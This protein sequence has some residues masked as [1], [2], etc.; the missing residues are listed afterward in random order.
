L[1]TLGLSG[2]QD[3][4]PGSFGHYE[5]R[6]QIGR[7]SMGVVYEA[8]HVNL[9]RPVALKMISDAQLASPLAR[10][11]FAIEAEAAAK[12]DH[13]NIVRIFEFGEWDGQPFLT[14]TL[15]QGESLREKIARGEIRALSNDG[16]TTNTGRFRAI[17]KMMALVARAVHHAHEHGVLHRDLKPANILIDTRGQPHLTDFGLAK[18]LDAPVPGPAPS[19][20]GAVLGT[21]CYMSPE[22]ATGQRLS[23][24]TDVYGL[25]AVLYELLTGRPPFKAPTALETMR[26]LTEQAPQRPRNLQ[27]QIPKD[28][29]TVCLKCLERHPDSRYHSAEALAEDLERWLEQRPILARPAKPLVRAARW[30]RRNPLGAALIVSL[31]GCLAGTLAWLH[32]TQKER[33]RS[34]TVRSALT[35]Q[36]TEQIEALWDDPKQ[37]FVRITALDLASLCNY[38]APVLGRMNTIRLT[39]DLDNEEDPIGQA[40]AHAPVLRLLE[41]KMGR[42]LHRPVVFDIR[43]HKPGRDPV[44]AAALGLADVQR[45]GPLYYVRA[46]VT[47]PGLE[48]I[49]SERVSKEAVIFARE[50]LGL[51]N[52]AQAKGLRIAFAHTNACISFWAMVHFVRAGITAANIARYSNLDSSFTLQAEKTFQDAENSSHKIVIER[53]L[54]GEF[55]L[56]ESRR[57]QF[58]RHRHRGLV[59]LYRFS[60]TPDLY[61]ARPGLD[62]KVVEALREALV[63]F[64]TPGEKGLLRKLHESM[65]DGFE[66]ASDADFD[67][68]RTALTTE[69]ARFEAP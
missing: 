10:R 59:E 26:L 63:S 8:M 2:E 34:E 36:L 24:A 60:A 68:I 45:M 32:L 57:N 29:E 52:L 50:E 18:I 4:F 6:R 55:D 69:V 31:C 15:V 11:R 58:E 42:T 43:V 3:L 37:S 21:P 56:G 48:P 67:E 64:S 40:M 47:A 62:P 41:Q 35:W 54:A 23:A 25:G 61:V 22:Q 12:L 19:V 46:K 65:I 33:Q 20:T 39:L 16:H 66:P 7:G 44:G 28:L 5:L 49:A 1:L 53:V 14:M 51:T 9:H 13:P 17:T 27:K 30:T 38:P